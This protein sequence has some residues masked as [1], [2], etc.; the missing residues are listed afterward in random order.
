MLKCHSE[1]IKRQSEF[2]GEDRK[3]IESPKGWLYE[4][5]KYG[6]HLLDEEIELPVFESG[7]HIV[8]FVDRLRMQT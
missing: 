5:L 3:G 2:N 1:K 8:N 7:E 4:C 6:W